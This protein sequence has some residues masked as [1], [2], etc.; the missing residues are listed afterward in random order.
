MSY[1]AFERDGEVTVDVDGEA[2]RLGREELTVEIEPVEGFAAARDRGVTVGLDLALDE[3][4]RREGA[5][6]E[7]VNRIQNARKR[8]GLEV[9]DRI[10]LRY[11]GPGADWVFG[12]LGELIAGE[13][14]ALEWKRLA[15]PATD[16]GGEDAGPA[17]TVDLEPGT[18]WVWI[19]RAD[20]S[21]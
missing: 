3:E 14:L 12:A 20:D 10:R 13:T 9:T 7:L 19:E 17:V 6:R 11:W 21:D 2:V 5:A 16:A 18:A 15:E 1:L 8:A 4:L